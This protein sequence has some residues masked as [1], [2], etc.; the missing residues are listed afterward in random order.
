MYRSMA[1]GDGHVCPVSG[2]VA[3]DDCMIPSGT[4]CLQFP[5]RPQLLWPTQAPSC[6]SGGPLPPTS[7]KPTLPGG[8]QPVERLVHASW[9][10]GTRQCRSFKQEKEEK[11]ILHNDKL[12]T[13]Q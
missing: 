9:G 7:P 13:Y 1:A 8:F 11:G 2:G 4:V 5:R 10:S 3:M 12:N 6:S